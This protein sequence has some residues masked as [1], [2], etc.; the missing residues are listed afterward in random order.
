VHRKKDIISEFVYPI[1]K[2]LRS[3][4]IR[5]L[6]NML[7]VEYFVSHLNSIFKNKYFK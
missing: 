4:N 1:Y 3:Q 2:D 5:N 6:R 7:Y